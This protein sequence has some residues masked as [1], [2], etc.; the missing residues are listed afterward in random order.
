MLNVPLIGGPNVPLFGRSHTYS[1]D[2]W[3]RLG[4]T[5]CGAGSTWSRPIPDGKVIFARFEPSVCPAPPLA[6]LEPPAVLIVS[7]LPFHGASRVAPD[8]MGPDDGMG[9]NTS[10]GDAALMSTSC[11]PKR[12]DPP[13]SCALLF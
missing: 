5:S 13:S 6:L 9:L 8:G 7:P 3:Y 1:N 4:P 12:N 11:S 2:I 10:G